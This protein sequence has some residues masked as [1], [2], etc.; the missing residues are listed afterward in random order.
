MTSLEWWVT[1]FSY[2]V[3]RK[4]LTPNKIFHLFENEEDTCDIFIQPPDANELNDK[5]PGKEELK[6]YV[7]QEFFN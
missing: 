4:N 2:F 7:S 3:S 5:G 6:I 1:F